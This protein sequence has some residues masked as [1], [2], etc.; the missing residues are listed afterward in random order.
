MRWIMKQDYLQ[1]DALEGQRRLLVVRLN[2]GSICAL[3]SLGIVPNVRCS[4]LLIS[5][6]H[7]ICAACKLCQW[8]DKR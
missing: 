7:E 6:L 3:Y 4:V 5:Q 8:D 1:T 2:A